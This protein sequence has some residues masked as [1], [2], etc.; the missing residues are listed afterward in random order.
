MRTA[1]IC[2][3]IWGG[4]TVQTAFA[5]DWP[6]WLGPQR[7]PVWRENGIV[8]RSLLTLCQ[9]RSLCRLAA[10]SPATRHDNFRQVP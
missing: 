3:L 7:E 4:L 8:E 10:T 1:M 9:I 2:V 5:D 6:Q